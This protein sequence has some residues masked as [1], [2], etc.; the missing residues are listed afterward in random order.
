ML[1][2]P[3]IRDARPNTAHL[4]LSQLE[5]RGH[6]NLLI[7]QNVD[8]LHQRAGSQQVVDLHGRLDRVI[9]LDCRAIYSR[10]SVQHQLQR[11]NGHMQSLSAPSR[12]D[13]DSDL[14]QHQ[15]EMLRYPD[16]EACAG[17]LMPDV[18]FF[19]G[20]V[21]AERVQ[22]CRS[23]IEAADALLVVGSSLTVYSGFRFCRQ[24]EK[25]SKPIGIIN[26]GQTRGDPLADLRLSSDCGPLLA[27]LLA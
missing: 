8:R 10:E 7:T 17:T 20:S 15:I 4:A 23:A 21:P 22:R 26:P 11:V 25:L 16:C 24:A 5:T 3:L 6:V 9:C 12:P 14:P 2:W 18:V 13:G 19:G 27:G 1:G